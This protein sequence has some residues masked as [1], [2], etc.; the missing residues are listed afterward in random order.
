MKILIFGASGKTGQLLTQ[1]ALGRGHEVT[2]FVRDPGKL[3]VMGSKLKVVQGNV[4]ERKKVVTAVQGQDAVISALGA[5]NPFKNDPAL[6][7]GVGQIITA[8]ENAGVKR[9]VYLSFLG[10]KEHRRELG[11]VVDRLVPLFLHKVIEDHEAK[12][13]LIVNSCLDWS[14]VRPPKLTNGTYTGNYRHG[15][16]LL[17]NSL[18]PR[19]SRED[20]SE[21]MINITALAQYIHC[22]P[23]VMY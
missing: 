17:P 1:K 5:G 8:M 6:I 11:W 7:R 23:R 9:L 3:H 2:A 19:I 18:F 13:Q 4:V 10:V 14:L 22:K 21:F 16:H 20:L 15:E 12:E